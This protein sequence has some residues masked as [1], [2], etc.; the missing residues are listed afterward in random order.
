MERLTRQRQAVL[1]AL[2]SS[3]RTLSPPEILALAQRHAPG[4]NLSTVYRQVRSLEEDGTVLRVRLAG[5]ADRYELCC[6]LLHGPEAAPAARPAGSPR[7][8]GAARRRAA[9]ADADL[10]TAAGRHG[11][12]GSPVA[13]AHT[14]HDHP[15]AH[16]HHHHFHCLACDE[17]VPI[18]G[19]PGP[20]AELAPP[21]CS[22]ERHDLVLHG[23]CARCSDAR[24]EARP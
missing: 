21:G 23:R 8:A 5:Q 12:P 6:T 1:D 16:D 3:G 20:M 13:Q 11:G 10:G 22:V 18:H 2:S 14:A 4:M 19:C 7:S 17:V 9:R 15:A 24:T